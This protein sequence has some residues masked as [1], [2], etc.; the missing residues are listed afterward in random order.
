MIRANFLNLNHKR[1]KD[2]C[3]AFLHSDE[4][5]LQAILHL[6]PG[7]FH[8]KPV[9][10]KLAAC[11]G[12]STSRLCFGSPTASDQRQV[13]ALGRVNL[14]PPVVDGVVLL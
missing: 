7:G 14:D 6:I 3:W 11:G 13:Y 4:V 5:F 2:K 12:K 10:D 1:G 9:G 8:L